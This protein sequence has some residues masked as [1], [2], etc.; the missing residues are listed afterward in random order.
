MYVLPRSFLTGTLL[1]LSIG[2]A[3]CATKMQTG[4]AVGAAGGAAAGGAVGAAAGNTAAGV[5]LG[6]VIGG[7]AG[8]LI[9]NEMDKQ[10]KQLEQNIPGATVERLGEGIKITFDSGLLFGFNSATLTPEA[11]TNLR[12]LAQSFD[13][14]PGTE[15]LIVGH[16]DSVGGSDYNQELSERRSQSAQDYLVMQ[17]VSSSRIATAALGEEEPVAS[18]DSD[19]GRAQ[20]RRVEV[21][22]YA[23]EAMRATAQ[24][25]ADG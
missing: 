22:I 6:A 5:I 1:V 12:N 18:N 2:M 16:T 14:Y 8:A 19:E 4:A 25:E 24:D 9:G 13:Q 7:T 21:A 15:I 20:N 17:G 3:G 10:A 23:S 11:R